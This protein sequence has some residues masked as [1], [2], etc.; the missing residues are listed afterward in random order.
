MAIYLQR[1]DKIMSTKEDI[2]TVIDIMKKIQLENNE[3]IK[4]SK[5]LKMILLNL[6]IE[7]ARISE[8]EKTGIDPIIQKL[9]ESIERIEN[10]VVNLVNENRTDLNNSLAN[11]EKYIENE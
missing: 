9:N 7:D 2:K 8:K 4:I 3:I 1:E 11:L 6:K 5:T 10:G